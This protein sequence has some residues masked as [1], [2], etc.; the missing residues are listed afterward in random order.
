MKK[1]IA[2]SLKDF[3]EPIDP[4]DPTEFTGV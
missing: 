4:L 2:E 3:A 1:A